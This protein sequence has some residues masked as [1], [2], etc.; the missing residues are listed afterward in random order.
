MLNWY[1]R[2]LAA[3]SLCSDCLNI[4]ITSGQ[5]P[6]WYSMLGSDIGS[7]A[8]PRRQIRRV[9]RQDR[10]EPGPRHHRHLAG[11][12]ER[13]QIGVAIGGRR[14]GLRHLIGDDEIDEE[15]RRFHADLAVEQHFHPDRTCRPTGAEEAYS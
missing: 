1:S 7:L 4:T 12:E 6:L 3:A 10:R 5:N 9:V 2:N 15:L 14:T 13:L 11:Q 8:I